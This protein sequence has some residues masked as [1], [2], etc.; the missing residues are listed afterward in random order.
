M[1]VSFVDERI[2]LLVAIFDLFF[3]HLHAFNENA[4]LVQTANLENILGAWVQITQL[5]KVFIAETHSPELCDIAIGPY[6][7]H[8]VLTGGA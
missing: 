2:R 7:V 1:Y 8:Y 5:F 4:S 6:L 3:L